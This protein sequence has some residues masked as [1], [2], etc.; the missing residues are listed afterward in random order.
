M[1]GGCIRRGCYQKCFNKMKKKLTSEHIQSIK[2]FWN[3]KGD[4]ESY[5][6]FDEILPI[7]KAEKPELIEA[8][9]DYKSA[10]KIMDAVVKSL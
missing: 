7:L 5:S 9:N 4:I 2:Y 1:Q 8:W 3:Y 10:E 6:L